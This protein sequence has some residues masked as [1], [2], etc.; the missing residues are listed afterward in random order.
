[1]IHQAAREL[2]LDVGRSVVIGD[3]WSDIAL[4]RAAGAR[5][6]LVRTGYGRTQE[7]KPPADLR[8]GRRRRHADGRHELDLDAANSQASWKLEWPTRPS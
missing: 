7:L 1:M 8:A 3:K 6:V 5:A 2:D 4:A